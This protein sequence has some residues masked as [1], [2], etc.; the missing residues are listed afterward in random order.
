MLNQ[1]FARM[2]TFLT[3]SWV[4]GAGF[5]AVALTALWPALSADW[6]VSLA[7]I[8]L[9]LPAYM[10]HQVEEHGGDRFRTFV[11]TVVCGGREGLTTADVLWINIG[12]VWVVDLAAFY[13]ARFIEPGWGLTAVYLMLV[14]GLSHLGGAVKFPGYNPGLVTS[15]VLFLPL[16]IAALMV[17]PGSLGQH[18]LGLAASVVIHAGIIVNLRR[19][20]A[21]I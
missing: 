19:R 16:S 1:G 10:I 14:N 17:V 6:P 9:G 11:N 13:A 8:Y 2:K 5:M 12:G 15:V 7:L 18:V 20:L 21:R 3:T 4:A